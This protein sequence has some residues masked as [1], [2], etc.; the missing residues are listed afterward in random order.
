MIASKVMDSHSSVELIL[1]IEVIVILFEH[2]QKLYV[3]IGL[4]HCS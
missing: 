3:S 2:R 4:Q 1:N